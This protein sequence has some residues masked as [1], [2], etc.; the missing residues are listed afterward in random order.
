GTSIPLPTGTVLIGGGAARAE[1][2]DSASGSFAIVAGTARLGGQ[3]SAA[4]LLGNG[5]VLITGGYGSGQG[6]TASAWLYRP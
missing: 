4:A 5:Q 6:P 3:F 1:I 2:Y